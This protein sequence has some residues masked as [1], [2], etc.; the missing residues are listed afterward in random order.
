[1][2]RNKYPCVCDSLQYSIQCHRKSG[3]GLNRGKMFETSTISI[4]EGFKV[5]SRLIVHSFNC[6]RSLFN[7]VSIS[8]KSEDST[9]FTNTFCLLDNK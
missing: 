5:I 1:M 8:A 9:P 4:F 7:I 6:L 3:I 2:M